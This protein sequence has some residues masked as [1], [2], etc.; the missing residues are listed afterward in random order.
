M[1]LQR[2]NPFGDRL[3][4]RLLHALAGGRDDV[5]EVGLDRRTRYGAAH[6]DVERDR[7]SRLQVEARSP[8]ASDETGDRLVRGGT[9]VGA[10][11]AEA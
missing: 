8:R 1:L 9:E 10:C 11:N 6:L 3:L 5:R 2:V 4:R 7:I